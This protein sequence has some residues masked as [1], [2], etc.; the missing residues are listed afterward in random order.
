MTKNKL[1]KMYKRLDLNT[2]CYT[3]DIFNM[4]S[5]SEK[6]IY[7]LNTYFY[8]EWKNRGPNKWL[9]IH[10]NDDTNYDHKYYINDESLLKEY[11]TFSKFNKD[12]ESSFK[13]WFAHWCAFNL[14][15]LNL[16]IWKFK[17]L[18]HDFEIPWMKIFYKYDV[19][20]K[21]HRNN[22]KHHLE[23]GLKY[24]WDNVDWETLMIDWEC[25]SFTKQEEQ[26]DAREK[27]NYEISKEKWVQYA[28]QIKDHLEPL[29][30]LYLL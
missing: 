16:G 20:Q 5:P 21:I 3:V 17:Y 8:N 24:G 22:N 6:D 7:Y 23:Y 13:Y 25:R 2:R 18:F 27:L 30:N 11:K 15:A 29:L 12:N 14:T 9:V 19:V 4:E 10:F 28:D 26:F 1:N